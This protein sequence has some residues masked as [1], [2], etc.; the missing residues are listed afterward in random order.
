MSTSIPTVPLNDK[1][2][3][4]VIGFG[5]GSALYGKDATTYVVQA[6][7]GGFNHIDTAQAYRN[8]ES[9]GEALRK[10][11]GKTP[12]LYGDEKIDLEKQTLG[13][14]RREDIWITTKYGGNGNAE[15]ALD[16]SLEKL[17]LPSVDL[18]LIHNPRVTNDIVKTWFELE[19]AHS[20]GKAKSIGVSNFSV[21]QLKLVIEHGKVIPSVNQIRFH[22]YNYHENVELLEFAK[23]HNIVIESYSGLTPITKLPGGKLD[24]VLANIA[25]RLGPKATPAQVIMQWIRAKGVVVVTTTSRKERIQEYLGIF[26]LPDLTE[27]E[28]IEI[29]EA[30]REPPS[31]GTFFVILVLSSFKFSL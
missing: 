5:T 30:A 17:G 16:S 29:D 23:K 3:L 18:Y 19:S 25:A 12:T 10:A 8:E 27:A 15:D 21:E 20:R 24:N 13:N 2:E 9:V 14:V 26:G 31:A 7:E 22:P 11:F 6:L 4:P 28:I 1:R